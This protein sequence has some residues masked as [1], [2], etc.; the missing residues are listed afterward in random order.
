MLAVPSLAF[1]YRERRESNQDG[2][3]E[4]VLPLSSSSWPFSELT[5]L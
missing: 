4:N 5:V 3:G 2:A 1:G